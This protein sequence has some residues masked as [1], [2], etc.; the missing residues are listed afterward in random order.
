[1]LLSPFYRGRHGFREVIGELQLG[2]AGG[3]REDR[4]GLLLPQVTRAPPA[5]AGSTP[6][7]SLKCTG[8]VVHSDFS[9]PR[10]L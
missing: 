10:S 4:P 2:Q 9:M 5:V 6:T 7:D 3:Q 8:I 1:M